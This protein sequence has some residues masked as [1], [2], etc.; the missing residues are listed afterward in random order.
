MPKVLIATTNPSKFQ[1]SS[2]CLAEEGVE[3][4]GL[5]DF[6]NIAPPEESGSTFEENALLKAKWYFAKTG[7]PCTADD[8]GLLVDYLGG[9]PG[10]D[11][12]RWLGKS[13]TDYELAA[14]ILERL[15]GIPQPERTARLGACIVFWDGRHLLKREYF[16]EGY[17]ADRLMGEVKDGF[18]YRAIFMI[19]QFGKPYCDLTDEEH[20]QVN[21]RRKTLKEL[22]PN[23]FKLLR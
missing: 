11:S 1:E 8:G 6:P 21:F 14:A 4:L 15:Q 23:I 17:I 18:P 13:A 7:I 10:V 9:A 22:K 20:E 19:P 3:I 2:S 16:T 5:R 12:H